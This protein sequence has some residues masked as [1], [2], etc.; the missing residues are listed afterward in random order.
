MTSPFLSVPPSQWVA[1]NELAFA[2]RDSHPVTPGHTL[3]VPRRLIG[4]F[5]EATAEEREALLALVAEVRQAL[6]AGPRP[7]DGYNVGFNEGE[8]AGQTV[9]HLHLHVIPRYR[10]DMYDP[11][12]G[13][14]HVIP[15]K[16]NYLRPVPE[17]LCT[18]GERDPFLRHL[19]PLFLAARDITIVVAQVRDGGLR[20]LRG[21]LFGALRRGALVRLLCG[22]EPGGG[23]ALRRLLSWMR[24]TQADPRE[25]SISRGT[26]EVRVLM[27]RRLPG[28]TRAVH[29]RCW[30]FEGPGLAV[31]YVGSSDLTQPALTTAIEWN[32]RQ[33]RAEDGGAYPRISAAVE[34][35]WAQGVP[36][37][38]EWAEANTGREPSD[39]PEP[40]PEPDAL[41]EEAL[42]ALKRRRAA[43]H[44]RALLSLSPEIDREWLAVYDVNAFRGEWGALP[45][46]LCLSPRPEWLAAAADAFRRLL[47]AEQVEGR[48]VWLVGGEEDALL[49]D[50]ALSTP[51]RL[52]RP[53]TL[54]HLS[55]G[56]FD[57][58]IL[59][60]AGSATR[61]AYQEVLDQL[62][63]RFALGLGAACDRGSEA[64]VLGLFDDHLGFRADLAAGLAR[65][66]LV[67]FS[68]HA[69][70][71][72]PEQGQSQRLR[73]ER[74]WSAWQAHPARRTLLLCGSPAE[75]QEARD[76]L[77]GQGV[78]AR[79]VLTPETAAEGAMAPGAA[80]PEELLAALAGGAI[81]AACVS[82]LYLEDA[83]APGMDRLVLLRP[84]EE[85]ARFLSWLGAGLVPEQGKPRL[86]VLDLLGAQPRSLERLRTLLDLHAGER[87]GSLGALLLRH[88]APPLPAGCT[89]DVE[90]ALRAALAEFLPA[91]AGSAVEQAYREIAV[92]R[93]VRPRAAELFRLGHDVRLLVRAHFGWFRFVDAAGHLT[94]VEKR[95]LQKALLWFQ[96]LEVTPMLRSFRMA[97]LLA[98][99]EAGGLLRGLPLAPLSERGLAVLLRS[100]ELARDLRDAEELAGM[101]WERPDEARF[102]AFWNRH[103]V[104]E[105]IAAGTGGGGGR[106]WFRVEGERLVPELPIGPGEADGEGVAFLQMTREL[107][108]Y[109]LAH[110]RA[111]A[112]ADEGAERF[113]CKVV[114]GGSQRGPILRLPA[115]RP[116]R[117]PHGEVEVRLPDGA[118]WRFRFQREYC[119]EA[120]PAGPS[121]S[122]DVQEPERSRLAELLR[123]WF[124]PTA[125]HP[126]TIFPVR[127][128]YDG[129]GWTAA[130]ETAPQ[131]ETF[132]TQEKR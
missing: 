48:F 116:G 70:L 56:F 115:K 68:Y 93:G 17:P 108:E 28:Q 97:L 71:D 46:V 69:L 47:A 75:A 131:S 8:A 45:R 123:G 23:E 40:P 15:R 57:Y 20:A 26:L 34:E 21:P 6:D 67:P 18:G 98:L 52:L 60:Q 73:L 106:A 30:R 122:A 36:L 24:A 5:F 111:R 121:V 124:G 129:K 4:S 64:E 77:E 33:S 90:E 66:R 130:P 88:E 79:A 54:A 61:E 80:E 25:R 113:T 9:A 2:I 89:V 50:I 11:R 14:R 107:V 120:R 110:Y 105:W 53:E 19:R 63:P 117:L 119:D 103:P 74:L 96:D 29:A 42:L 95:V 118:R 13:V 100:P 102:L 65:G 35:L 7:P 44:H 32:L 112:R 43:G 72:G 62:Q 104:R 109:R 91:A 83:P 126:G 22:D 132:L 94:E 128:A 78:R 82:E 31:A 99:I 41:L 86:Q 125:G 1:A 81:D 39:R 51:A 84:V 92:A 76:F 55:P 85:P 12:G 16:G 27:Q 3:V 49:G 127:F 114:F 58:V 10:G 37:A 38:E 87:P 101:D 59:D